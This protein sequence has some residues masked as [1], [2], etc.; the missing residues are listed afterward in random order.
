[1][2]RPSQL[3]TVAGRT[4]TLPPLWLTGLMF[5]SAL[6][7]LQLL[8]Y[9]LLNPSTVATAVDWKVIQTAAERIVAGIS[10]YQP[11]DEFLW[12]WSPLAAWL[13]VPVVQ[14]GVVF[15]VALHFAALAL[16]R[17]RYM[18]G[19]FLISF[20]FWWDVHVGN[21]MTFVVVAGVL[22]IRGTFAGQLAFGTL[23]LLMPRPLMLP[24]LLWL[25]WREPR[26]RLPYVVLA[27]VHGAAVIAT[28]F[29]ADWLAV[30]FMTAQHHFSANVNFGPSRLIGQWWVPIGLAL[31]AWLTWKGRIGQA[32]LVVSPYWF[33]QYFLTVLL[34][35][36]RRR[37]EPRDRPD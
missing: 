13:L 9:M 15:W 22:A 37:K 25:V 27:L 30:L 11:D 19:L 17:D 33:P 34:D 6:L 3:F 18:I 23:A 28:G 7:S 8:I 26:V 2:T 12:L 14:A 10:P 32:S 24:L 29:A 4:M 36:R 35:A 5:T 21:T 1:M 16:L 31:G 20:P